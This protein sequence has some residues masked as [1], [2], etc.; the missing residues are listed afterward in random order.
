MR[1]GEARERSAVEKGSEV[2][3]ENWTRERA[4]ERVLSVVK[5]HGQCTQVPR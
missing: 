5:P 3:L 2:G 4:E 1:D